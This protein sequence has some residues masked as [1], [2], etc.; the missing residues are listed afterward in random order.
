MQHFFNRNIFVFDVDNTLLEWSNPTVFLKNYKTATT[1]L[2]QKSILDHNRGNRLP[3]NFKKPTKLPNYKIPSW[4]LPFF[5]H[6]KAKKQFVAIFSDIPH[7]EL[8][9]M[10]RPFGVS[11]IIDGQYIQAL[12][13]L[14]DGLWQLASII[15]CNP[16]QI[17]MIGDQRSTDGLSAFN[18]G[19]HFY[20]ISTLKSLGLDGFLETLPKLLPN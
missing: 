3:I 5:E 2:R 20:P 8:E 16:N 9:D 18:V 15:G 13:P 17:I 4:L 6:L 14:P 12:K 7:T 19:A 10:L 1:I 11:V